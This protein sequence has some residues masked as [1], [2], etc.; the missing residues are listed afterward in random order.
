MITHFAPVQ[1]IT[2]KYKIKMIYHIFDFKV[3]KILVFI[4]NKKEI[5][6]KVFF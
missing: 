4:Q 2:D 5:S 6:R 3:V 1:K